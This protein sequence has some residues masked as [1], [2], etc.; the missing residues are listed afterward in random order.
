MHDTLENVDISEVNKF[1]GIAGLWWDPKGPFRGLHEMNPLRVA[2]IAR[3]GETDGKTILD[4]GC[5]GGI[6]SEAMARCGGIVTGIDMNRTALSVARHHRDQSG[7][8]ID[9]RHASADALAGEGGQAYDIITCMEVLEHVP[10]PAALIAA[11]ARL[12]RP[13]G[14]LFISTINRTFWSYLLAIVIAEH[15]L[16]LT[17]KNT[18]SYNKFIRPREL[19][20]WARQTGF[21]VGGISGILYI[22]YVPVCRLIP[23]RSVNYIGHLIKHR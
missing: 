13:G 3:H 18:H 9:Y 23:A 16:G 17:E 11:C 15:L 14:R 4:V 19:Q 5:G 1:S 2:Y 21:R 22:P 7:L 8:I 20:R 6:L 12:V 10:D